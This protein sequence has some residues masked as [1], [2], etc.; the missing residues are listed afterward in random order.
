MSHPKIKTALFIL[1]A[2]ALTLTACEFPAVN[3]PEEQIALGIA[4]TQIA[5]TQTALAAQP[6]PD[7]P[8]QEPD[9][10]Q[11]PAEAS[12]TQTPEPS[13]T[14][15]PTITLSPTQ[16]LTPTQDRPMVSVSRNTNCRTGPGE[17]Y[18]I[19]GALLE[20]EEAEVVGIS[21]DGGTW[22]IKNPDRAGQC[23]LWGFYATVSGPTEGLQV[24]DTPPTPTPVFSWAGSWT[25]YVGPID[26]PAT[27]TYTLTLTV[28]G[29]DLS[30]RLDPGG[31]DM[32]L[33]GTISSDYLTA[34]GNW[35]TPTD[36]GTFKFYALGSN[37]FQGNGSNDHG[38]FKWCGGR[39]GAGMPSPCYKP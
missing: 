14:P 12:P 24:Y 22:I 36:N 2:L 7:Q 3:N 34:S 26:A 38:P 21:A 13:L 25:A 31:M 27:F 16:T 29:V 15:S 39:S 33:S 35:S 32:N 11:P 1:L 5:F 4:Q 18:D 19:I 10:L 30:G 8:T 28:N 9:D 6:N 37:Q 17:P 23:W 20:N